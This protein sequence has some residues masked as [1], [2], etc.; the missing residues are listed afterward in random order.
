MYEMCLCLGEA[1]WIRGEILEESVSSAWSLVE[2]RDYILAGGRNEF[3]AL[4]QC[5]LVH[6]WIASVMLSSLEMYVKLPS[7]HYHG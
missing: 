1:Y 6:D 2:V 4:V 5:L 7:V 3:T